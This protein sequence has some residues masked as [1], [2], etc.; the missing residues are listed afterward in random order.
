MVLE[1][2][3]ERWHSHAVLSRS[4][5]PLVQTPALVSEVTLAAIRWQVSAYS[6]WGRNFSL[7]VPVGYFFCPQP[8]S[9]SSTVAGFS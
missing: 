8:R 7:F 4:G 5:T 9:P 6:V 1:P 3:A 2:E